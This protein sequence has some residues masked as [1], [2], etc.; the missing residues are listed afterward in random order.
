MTAIQ[1]IRSLRIT[2]K[3]ISKGKKNVITVLYLAE[4]VL[5]EDNCIRYIL[6][7]VIQIC[8]MVETYGIQV[9]FQILVMLEF[10]N[11]VSALT[12]PIPIK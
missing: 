8:Y 10:I 12:S 4:A 6:R 11:G 1:N 9:I 7:N 5:L 3:G 2:E